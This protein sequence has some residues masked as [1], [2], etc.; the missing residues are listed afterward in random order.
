MQ[1]GVRQFFDEATIEHHDRSSTM[2]SDKCYLEFASFIHCS[3][4]CS[5]ME[6]DCHYTY[7]LPAL[8][9]EIKELAEIIQAMLANN[10]I[11]DIA[12][13]LSQTS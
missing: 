9:R 7:I 8:L 11:Q 2:Q 5:K 13:V 4:L 12:E 1:S 6:L 10:N 3:T